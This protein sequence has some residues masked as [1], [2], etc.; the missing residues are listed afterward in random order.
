[1]VRDADDA[2]WVVDDTRRKGL[3]AIGAKSGKLTVAGYIL[4]SRGGV[5]TLIVRCACGAPEHL[6]DRS[7]YRNFRSTRCNAC[8]KVAASRKRYWAYAQA[9]PDDAHRT[10]LLNRLAAA[11]TRCHSPTCRTYKHYGGRGISVWPEWRADRVAFLRYVQELPGWD[12]PALEMDREENSAGYEPGNIRFVSRRK[13][14]LNKRKVEDLEQRIRD[15]EACLRS[16][17]RGT[18]APLH[19]LD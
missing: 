4:G 9:M 8:A 5:Q 1:V 16:G 14:L 19:D 7:N 17:E 12:N 6:V 10:R 15:L 11:I 13:N 3:P 18:A 2:R